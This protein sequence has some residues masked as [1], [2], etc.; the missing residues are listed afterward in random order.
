MLT[1]RNIQKA[2]GP[3]NVLEGTSWAVAPG[4]RWG[5]V[6]PNGSGKT[7]LLRILC[8]EESPDSGQVDYPGRT[9]ISYLPQEGGSLP[10][11]TLLQAILSSFTEIAAI[12]GEIQELQHQM[13]EDTSG[14]EAISTR[15]GDLQHK[16]EALG[17]FTL[18]SEARVV[19]AGLGFE[20]S[21]HARPISEF[22]GGYRTRALLGSLLLRK[23]DFLLMD[24]PTNHLDMEGIAWL[25]NYL[26]KLPSAMVIVSHDRAFLNKA[27]QSIAELDRGQIQVYAGNYDKYRVEKEVGRSR[28]QAAATREQKREAEVQKFIDRFRYKSTKAKQVQDRI[29]MLSRQDRTEV[30]EEAIPWNFRFPETER[31]PRAVL[32]LEDVHKSYGETKVLQGLNLVVER[33]DRIALVGSNGCGK[34]TLLKIIAGRQTADDGMVNLGEKVL[35]NYAAQHVLE[36]LSP[37]RTV[38]EELEALAPTKRQGELR[39][40]LGIFQFSGDDVFKLVGSLSGGEKNRLAMSRLVLQPGNFLLL[41]EPTNH[42][43]LPAREALEEALLAFSGSVL[44]VSHDR[45]FVNRVAR[46]VAGFKDGRLTVV[47]GDYDAYVRAT[48]PTAEA[49]ESKRSRTGKGSGG[50]ARLGKKEARRA[51]A[52]ARNERN[53]A[54]RN[55]QKELAGLEVE[56]AAHEK[57]LAEL[58]TEMA[59]PATYK[60]E[61]SAEVLGREQKKLS[62]KLPKLMSRWEELTGTL[63]ETRS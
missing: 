49:G 47:D 48:D 62:G 4:T 8:G 28:A 12:E 15:L 51:A 27:V 50:G 10:E 22:S 54:I 57:R 45:Y 36:A 52:D 39:G 44:F 63:N 19:L 16:F 6:G 18:E 7:T 61:G 2:F 55:V 40:L 58:S 53:R 43:D 59:D 29:K 23:P 9:S 20:T 26:T 60:K 13:A 34:S 37:K 33:G 41:D 30:V 32:S 3:Y 14:F 1:A 24:E 46:K 5:L 25:E 38:L 21:D 11:G 17:G 42:L 35:L 56:I 31:L